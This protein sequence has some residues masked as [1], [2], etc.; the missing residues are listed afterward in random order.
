M[1]PNSAAAMPCIVVAAPIT[2][3]QITPTT[4]WCAATKH[5]VASVNASPAN[6]AIRVSPASRP[7]I[8]TSV[9]PTRAAKPMVLASVAS[10]RASRPNSSAT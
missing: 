1:M 4:K 3:M 6:T 7:R 8:A 9:P 10:P 2:P 5:A